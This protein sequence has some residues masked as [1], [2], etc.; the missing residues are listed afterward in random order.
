MPRKNK[1]KTPKSC[2]TGKRNPVRQRNRSLRGKE[3]DEYL[4][5]CGELEDISDGNKDIIAPETIIETSCSKSVDIAD[6]GERSEQGS[7]D[8]LPVN[9]GFTDTVLEEN[10]TEINREVILKV[11]GMTLLSLPEGVLEFNPRY[12]RDISFAID[13]GERNQWKQLSNLGD[14]FESSSDLFE[15]L[16][17]WK[18]DVAAMLDSKPISVADHQSP[19]CTKGREYEIVPHE[20]ELELEHRGVEIEKL[21]QEKIELCSEVKMLNAEVFELHQQLK[22]RDCRIQELISSDYRENLNREYQRLEKMAEISDDQAECLR[23]EL[24]SS[25]LEIAALKDNL[26]YYMDENIKIKNA[27]KVKDKSPIDTSPAV[28]KD[29]SVQQKPVPKPRPPSSFPSNI[30]TIS[31]RSENSLLDSDEFGSNDVACDKSDTCVHE[32]VSLMGLGTV[33]GS[34]SKSTDSDVSINDISMIDMNDSVIDFQCLEPYNY[35]NRYGIRISES[36]DDNLS[37]LNESN[38]ENVG[39]IGDIGVYSAPLC[40]SDNVGSRGQTETTVEHGGSM[41]K[42]VPPQRSEMIEQGGTTVSTIMR[43][44]CITIMEEYRGRCIEEI[45]LQDYNEGRKFGLSSPAPPTRPLAPSNTDFCS[46]EPSRI[47]PGHKAYSEAHKPTT[48]IVADSTIRNVKLWQLKENVSS[49]DSDIII[50][51]HPGATADE[52]KHFIKDSLIRFSPSKLIIFAG[53]N[54]ISRA[55]KDNRDEYDVVN[56]IMEMAMEGRKHGCKEVFVSSVLTRWEQQYITTIDRVN[57]LLERVCRGE[58][59]NFL[60]HC[61]ITKDHICGDGLHPN[62][63]GTTVLKMNILSCFDGFNPYLTSFYTDYEYAY[64]GFR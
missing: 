51:R 37:L 56:S 12:V 57:L 2:K 33:V 17:D 28:E 34:R 40:E 7:I 23:R 18:Y 54:D 32:T 5:A 19:T 29:V 9:S 27:C 13:G 48:L 53:C 45:R 39:S 22:I 49:T 20:L 44:Q 64:H 21:Y 1:T 11:D 63:N 24:E 50:R 60:N 36:R 25:S 43:N 61:D 14:I 46:S 41:I 42:F 38:S 35:G 10:I 58:G 62:A 52:M 30:S 3:S 15:L 8:V 6:L 55:K 16:F 59:V 31:I 26:Q 4:L 47:V